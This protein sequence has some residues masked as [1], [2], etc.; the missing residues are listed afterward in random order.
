M[1]NYQVKP[2]GRKEFPGKFA[3]RWQ[4]KLFTRIRTRRKPPWSS[5][6]IA[7]Q[8]YHESKPNDVHLFFF[9]EN[10][11]KARAKKVRS[12]QMRLAKSSAIYQLASVEK[13]NARS[14]SLIW[15]NSLLL[16]KRYCAKSVLVKK[17]ERLEETKRCPKPFSTILVIRENTI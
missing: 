17:W 5:S 14:A 13:H 16:F 1:S 7:Q 4:N 2:T 3:T 6:K 9:G 12:Y 10:N 11:Q 15:G 8:S